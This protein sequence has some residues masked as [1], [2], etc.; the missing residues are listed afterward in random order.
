[1]K[2]LATLALILSAGL[3]QTA[4]AAPTVQFSDFIPDAARN[5]FNGFENIPNDGT[6][7]TG[8]AGPYTEGGITVQQINGDSGND[9]WVT[10]SNLGGLQQ[11]SYSWYPSSGDFGY[12]QI[13]LSGG[14][15]FQNV[16]MAVGSGFGGGAQTVLY[17]LL[18]KGVTV[19]AG[20]YAPGGSGYLG[21]AGGGFDTILLSDSSDASYVG[22]V[23]DGHFNALTLDSI[24][25]VPE[26]GTLALVTAGLAGF[27][28]FRR[29]A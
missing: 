5:H 6:F 12:T 3:M 4:Q 22:S 28:G 7:Y 20:S 18:D 13:T 29:K 25:A 26:P 14:S 27:G 21:F 19:L 9:I 16:G 8:G 2:H 1:M 24:E 23:T 15:E 17:E 10:N 11:G